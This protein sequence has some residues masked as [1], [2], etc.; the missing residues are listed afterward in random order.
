M[1][2]IETPIGD[3]A[4]EPDLDYQSV[5][6]PAILGLLFGLLSAL[7]ML[8]PLGCLLAVLG[9][10]VSTIALRQI[11]HAGSTMVGRKTALAGLALSI[12]FGIAAPVDRYATEWQLAREAEPIVM[13][14]FENFR[15]GEPVLSHQM[16][17]DYVARRPADSVW[18][19][20]RNSPEARHGLEHYVV[21]P[22]V[23]VLL[24]L[25]KGA[26]VRLYETVSVVRRDDNDLVNQI[27][28]VTYS[29]AKTGD[30]RTFF[31]QVAAERVVFPPTG[32]VHWRIANSSGGVRP[33]SLG[34]P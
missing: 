14:W 17:L 33:P 22:L 5:C 12:T 29:D 20:Y 34:G 18:E 21:D 7:G 27:Y 3:A 11:E 19:Y 2:Q 6:W 32:E 4:P 9:V 10:V 26:D 30:R 15:F 25:A 28:A 8:H 1:S 23:S 13:K 24:A 31:V 16:G